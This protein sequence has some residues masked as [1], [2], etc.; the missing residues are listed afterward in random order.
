MKYVLGCARQSRG[1]PKNLLALGERPQSCVKHPYAEQG[2]R[3][4]VAVALAP[5]R[6]QG[7]QPKFGGP[8]VAAL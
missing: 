8:S 7:L 5:K 3:G 2:D 6:G 1:L 4:T